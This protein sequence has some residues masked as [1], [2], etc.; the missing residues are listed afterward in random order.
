M[1]RVTEDPE[2]RWDL[3]RVLLVTVDH[4]ARASSSAARASR[5]SQRVIKLISVRVHG[6][7]LQQQSLLHEAGT[8]MTQKSG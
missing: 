2:R 4:L 8:R 7:H 5:W 6:N 3:G 1:D